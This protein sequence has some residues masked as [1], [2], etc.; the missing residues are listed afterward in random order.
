MRDYETTVV[1]MPDI[2][3]DRLEAKLDQL[4]QLFGEKAE[5]KDQGVQGL[6]YQIKR[7]TQAHYLLI[8][9]RNEPEKIAGI[10]AKLRLDETV[11]R[12]MTCR[13]E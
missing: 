8:Y 1:L 12:F 6:A 10:E 7:R 3:A 4:R 11:I 2:E 9:H 13:G 5:I